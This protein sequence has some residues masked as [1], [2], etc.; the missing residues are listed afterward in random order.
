MCSPP[1]PHAPHLSRPTPP[2]P[3]SGFCGRTSF[4]YLLSDGVDPV[5]VA[6]RVTIK[7]PCLAPANYTYELPPGGDPWSPPQ[8][9]LV[10][11]TSNPGCPVNMTLSRQPQAGTVTLGDSGNYTFNPPSAAWTGAKQGCGAA[12]ARPHVNW[13]WL[14]SAA[15]GTSKALANNMHARPSR[16]C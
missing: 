3:T 4:T 12:R 2:P 14:A 9:L 10:N 7:V 15:V 11:V 5:P 8:G 13:P 6:A 1:L 16:L